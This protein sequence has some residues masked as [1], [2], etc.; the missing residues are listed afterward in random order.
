MLLSEPFVK[1]WSEKNR[2]SS[3]VTVGNRQEL[4]L[5]VTLLLPSA[6]LTRF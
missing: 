1:S 2:L 4:L 6:K 3:Q 5:L